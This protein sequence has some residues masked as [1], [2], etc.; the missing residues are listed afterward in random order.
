MARRRR[1]KPE[2]Y[3]ESRRAHYKSNPDKYRRYSLTK[4]DIT[5][6]EY[7]A[8]LS[9]QGDGCACCGVTGNKDGARLFIDHCHETGTIRGII[10][11]KCNSG[12][13]A[14][15]DNV[16]G[17]RRALAYLASAEIKRAPAMRI[18]LLRRRA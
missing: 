6:E 7:D 8:M 4:Y 5:V 15:G 18:N 12:I 2:Q 14:L 9:G 10:C 3:R 11:R 17:L 16:E 13:G 1:N